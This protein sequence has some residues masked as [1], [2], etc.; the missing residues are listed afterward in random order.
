MKRI[1]IF[2]HGFGVAKDSNGLFADIATAFNPDIEPVLFD[3][4]DIDMATNTMTVH[5][6]GE[7]AKLLNEHIA[8]LRQDHPG[9][10]ITLIAHSQGCMVAALA[11]SKVD[12]VILLAAPETLNLERSERS[13]ADRRRPEH[14]PDGSIKLTRRKGGTV[15]ILPGF[16]SEIRSIDPP[17][18][19]NQLATHTSVTII[20]AAQDEML[21]RRVDDSHLDPS[22]GLIKLSGDHNFTDPSDRQSLITT[23][24][25]LI[26]RA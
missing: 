16:Q 2:S 10:P 8:Q 13:F 20:R 25:D 18:Q 15:I 6:L 21:G 7:Q 26:D 22:I 12:Q 1:V 3:Y 24:N 14:L 17:T 19:Y 23:I 9:I 4:N 11:D 5:S